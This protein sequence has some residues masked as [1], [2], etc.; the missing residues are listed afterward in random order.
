MSIVKKVQLAKMNFLKVYF[1]D[2][3]FFLFAAYG[4][5]AS[6]V[7]T[8]VLAAK[9]TAEPA[10]TANKVNPKSPIKF[11]TIRILFIS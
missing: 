8:A 1:E 7:L 2:H 5:I 9:I 6:T 3:H 10:A 4:V 11:I